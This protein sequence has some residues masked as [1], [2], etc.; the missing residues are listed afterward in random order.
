[1]SRFKIGKKIYK[2]AASY[3]KAFDKTKEGKKIA[4]KEEKDS[5]KFI[6]NMA[7]E[8]ILNA[9]YKTSKSFGDEVKTTM[10]ARLTRRG[11]KKIK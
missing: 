1:M 6:E 8:H 4:A 9:S 11:R 2:Y 7:D 10:G 5:I 3:K